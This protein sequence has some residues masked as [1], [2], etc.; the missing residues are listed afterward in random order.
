MLGWTVNLKLPN[1][2]GIPPAFRR[3]R[4][5]MKINLEF[6][7]PGIG[8]PTGYEDGN[9]ELYISASGRRHSLVGDDVTGVYE[10]GPGDAYRSVNAYLNGQRYE[11]V[12]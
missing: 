6:H 10:E 1:A 7:S 2:V 8:H 3:R 11:V 12:P 5:S 9:W 4:M